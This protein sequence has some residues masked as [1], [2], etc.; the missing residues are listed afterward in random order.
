MTAPKSLEI[1]FLKCFFSPKEESDF[2]GA[3]W[4][5]HYEIIALTYT[6]ISL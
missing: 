2:I 6:F 4:W 5:K 1:R 3:A